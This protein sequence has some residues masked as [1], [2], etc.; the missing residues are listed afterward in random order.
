MK[1][2]ASIVSIAMIAA[3]YGSAVFAAGPEA[4]KI[5]VNVSAT[6]VQPKQTFYVS[7]AVF[8][9]SSAPISTAKPIIKANPSY[10]V[11]VGN[12]VNCASAEGVEICG[13]MDKDLEHVDAAYVVPVTAKEQTGTVK[14]DVYVDKKVQSVT[15]NVGNAAATTAAPAAKPVVAAASEEPKAEDVKAGGATDGKMFLLAGLFLLSA[16]IFASKKGKGIK[17]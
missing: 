14:L 16:A 9:S 6:T 2:I 13:K 7:L 11:D 12:F 1:K 10:I 17:V 4:D 8:D 3:T 15:V 5:K